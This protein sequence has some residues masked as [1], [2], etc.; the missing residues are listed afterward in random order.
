MGLISFF[1]GTVLIPFS[2]ALLWKNEKKLVDFV[3]VISA[4]R[5]ECRAINIQQPHDECDYKL[6]HAAGHAINNEVIEDKVF[7]AS[8]E[9]AYRLVR[10]VEM[11]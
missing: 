4:A 9:N 11:Y 6:V 10:V 5:K 7:G 8:V 1:V 2:V 3:R